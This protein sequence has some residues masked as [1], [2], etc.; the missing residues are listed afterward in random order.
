[1]NPNVAHLAGNNDGN[2]DHHSDHTKELCMQSLAQNVV[3]K[4][5]F[6]FNRVGIVRFIVASA[7]SVKVGVPAL[8]NGPSSLTHNVNL[9]Y[10]K[11]QVV[12]APN[13]GVLCQEPYGTHCRYAAP[14]CA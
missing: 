10:R 13:P 5:K 12:K 1:M 9:C 4:Q 8:P 11:A 7:S 2:N 3:K 6:H 14:S